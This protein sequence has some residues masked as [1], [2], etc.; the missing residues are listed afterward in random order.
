MDQTRNKLKNTSIWIPTLLV[1][2]TWLVPK[3]ETR[4][5]ATIC[6]DYGS[7]L[8]LLSCPGKAILWFAADCICLISL[9]FYWFWL[10]LL[11]QHVGL[12]PIRSVQNITTPSQRAAI[13][14]WVGWGA[15]RINSSF[16]D[17]RILPPVKKSIKKKVNEAKWGEIRA[18]VEREKTPWDW[19]QKP[20]DVHNSSLVHM[21]P[22]RT[23]TP[24]FFF[25][26]FLK[27]QSIS[28][29]RATSLETAFTLNRISYRK[30]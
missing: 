8:I 10:T 11:L 16:T 23:E 6:W 12:N 28:Q 17:L 9:W 24:F 19:Y 29:E 15:H 27:A 13:S 22:C 14:V 2:D 25:F 18:L 30:E 4:P 26:P 7:P 21:K 1:R 5:I 20:T 3:I